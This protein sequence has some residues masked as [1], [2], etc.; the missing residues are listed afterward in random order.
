VTN[1][2]IFE[3]CQIVEDLLFLL[4]KKLIM[5]RRSSMQQIL[6]GNA[7]GANYKIFEVTG[8]VLNSSGRTEV[9]KTVIRHQGGYLLDKTETQEFQ[10]IEIELPNGKE[11]TMRLSNMNLPCRWHDI[12]TFWGPKDSQ[13]R[14]VA[15]FNHR[16]GHFSRNKSALASFY[17]SYLSLAIGLCIIIVAAVFYHN[18][19]MN[20]Y[21]SSNPYT[22]AYFIFLA[23]TAA[24]LPVLGFAVLV[25]RG[26]ANEIW[27]HL[28][29]YREKTFVSNNQSSGK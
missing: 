12:V 23:S 7:S 6:E 20:N 8:K 21:P 22:V 16:T 28:N 10:Y 17:I 9:T 4:I 26:R 24:A 29:K 11:A 13:F 3:R 19:I 18:Y 25:G 2:T 5:S 27:Y 15:T 1:S 14:P